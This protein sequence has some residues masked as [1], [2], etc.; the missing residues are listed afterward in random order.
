MC[1]GLFKSDKITLE[2]NSVG[3]HFAMSLPRRSVY[4]AIEMTALSRSVRLELSF[5]NVE[6][7][8]AVSSSDKIAKFFR[9]FSMEALYRKGIHILFGKVAL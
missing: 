2:I 3:C 8:I 9:I 5:S 1:F 4:M 6:A 7:I